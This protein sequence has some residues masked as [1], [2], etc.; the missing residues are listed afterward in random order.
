MNN[1]IFKNGLLISLLLIYI[2][3]Y[4]VVI[5]NYYLKY[6]EILTATFSL[7]LCFIAYMFYGFQKNFHN[8]IKNDVIFDVVIITIIFFIIYYGLGLFTGFLKNSYSLKLFMILKNMFGS[9]MMIIFIELFRYIY[10]RANS[11]KKYNLIILVIVLTL[12]DF[13]I[14]L[15]I[16]SGFSF[17][18][19][20]NYISL[21][22]IPVICR[23][24]LL[25][26]L[27]YKVSY[28]PCLIYSLFTQLYIYFVS[29]IP[30]IGNY[31]K[32]IFWFIL[33]IFILLF[34]DFKLKRYYYGVEREYIKKRNIKYEIPF[35]V[36]I[37]ILF[38]LVSGIF[39]YKLYGIASASMY[40]SINV[41]DAVIIDRSYGIIDED[42]IIAYKNNGKVIIHRVVS[43]EKDKRTYYVT[44]GDNNNVS[45]DIKV[46]DEDIEGK[47]VV[48]I[49]FIAYP[50]IYISSFFR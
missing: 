23:N 31:L 24:I 9:L 7:I 22:L 33:P 35:I 49:P 27:D 34:I 10:V 5:L 16:N 43:I 2:V 36:I 15:N 4:R 44:K 50:V 39:R 25:T 37:V 17:E 20:F 18:A 11:D 46:Y 29:I 21:L 41:G 3:L 1:R 40:P 8:K 14:K 12:F 47:I 26:Y 45:D 32:S 38:I 19:I 42:D 6:S 13:F 48:K 30:D 28:V